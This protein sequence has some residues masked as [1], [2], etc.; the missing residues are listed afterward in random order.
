MTPS[1]KVLIALIL[2]V[3]VSVLL[4]VFDVISFNYTEIIAYTLLLL[5]ISIFYKSFI[6]IQ[7]TGIF[8]GS[9]I[10]LTGI[11]LLTTSHFETSYKA[12]ILIP[13]FLIS[14]AVAFFMIFFSDK[15]DKKFAYLGFIICVMGIFVVVDQGIPEFSSY[16]ISIKNIVEKFWIVLVLIAVLILILCREK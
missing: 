7:K 2:F 4:S 16:I 8:F 11:A 1:K 13:A 9:F 12:P 5:G 10:F 3:W 15:S 14:V 6:K